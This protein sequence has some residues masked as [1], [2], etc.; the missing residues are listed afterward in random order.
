MARR[1]QPH[2]RR[3]SR[4]DDALRRSDR[5]R[6]QMLADVS[7]ELKTP[8]TAMRGYL[9]TLQM[10]RGRRRRPTGPAT[11]TPSSAKRGGS[12]ASSTTCSIWPAT[13][14]ASARSTCACS[15]SSGC[16]S[17][18]SGATSAT[19]QA[20]GVSICPSASTRPPIRW[21]AIRDRIEQVVDNLVANALRHTPTAARSRSTAS[22]DGQDVSLIGGRFR[23]RHRARAP[24]ARLRPVLQG[25]SRLARGGA[26]GSGLG[27]SIVKAI[28]ERH[29]G[30]I[31]VDSRPGRTAFTMSCRSQHRRRR[32]GPALSRASANL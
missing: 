10:P 23:R 11:S 19:P 7:H 20:R 24:A 26:G 21:S 4:R 32:P 15:P 5:L 27:L 9:E 18:S 8:L 28:V 3:S 22:A 6:R 1:V 2:G 14:T 25:R 30:T 17:T 13:R 12:S 29:G 31:D 16:S